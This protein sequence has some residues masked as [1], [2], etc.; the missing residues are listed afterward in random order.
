MENKLRVVFMGTPEFA[1]PS[2]QE[3]FKH[4]NLVGV[5]TAPDAIRKRGK[6]LTPTPVAET[7]KTLH[8]PLYKTKKIDDA[9]YAW[10]KS[11]QPEL[12]CVV[13]F[14]AL[15]P[16]RVL[17]LPRYGCINVHASLL[18][19]WRGAAPIERAILAGDSEL[20]VSIMKITPGLDEGDVC[21]TD[22]LQRDHL[23]HSEL[24][25]SLATMGGMALIKAI[26]DLESH[27]L[28]WKKQ[29]EALVT[30]ADKIQKSDCML[31]PTISAEKNFL[32]IQA[33]SSSHPARFFVNDKGIRAMWALPSQ[34]EV[35]QGVLCKEKEGVFLGCIEG[36]LEL[37]EVRPDG[38]REMSALDWARGLQTAKIT[39]S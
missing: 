1:L 39:W 20:G 15:L 21:L 26:N 10:L 38:K 6:E 22:L 29:D 31:S 3:V 11:L 25:N 24:E 7:A 36:S 33:S 14:G 18:P 13:A 4:F 8:V 9:A 34:K 23:R 12:I 5:M 2:L 35:D 17:V 37:L 27:K 32:R 28:S 19:R 30:Y 16:K